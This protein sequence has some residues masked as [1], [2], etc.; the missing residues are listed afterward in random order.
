MTLESA[1]RRST[2]IRGFAS[3]ETYVSQRSGTSSQLVDHAPAVG[4]GA[5]TPLQ[6]IGSSRRP[7]Q[8]CFAIYKPFHRLPDPNQKKAV[9]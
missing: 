5:V 9:A 6:V 2:M 8:W 1:V 4:R 3:S 7:V